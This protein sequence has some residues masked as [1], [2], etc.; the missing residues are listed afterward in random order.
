MY[1]NSK[2]NTNSQWY[3]HYYYRLTNHIK[4]QTTETKFKNKYT[5]KMKKN[6]INI[7]PKQHV[8]L[9]GIYKSMYT[10]HVC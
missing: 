2:I 1:S 6:D 7:V 10:N 4:D 9:S 8:I 3:N 5:S